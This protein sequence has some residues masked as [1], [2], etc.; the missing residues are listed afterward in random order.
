MAEPLSSTNNSVYGSIN[1]SQSNDHGVK[2]EHP[3]K[4]LIREI[5]SGKQSLGPVLVYSLIA[6][7]GACL[8]GFMLGFTSVLAINMHNYHYPSVSNGTMQ[9]IGVS[10][11]YG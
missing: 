1:E 3:I 6:V 8:N 9:Y 7:V 11:L 4:V 5:R 2:N 10:S